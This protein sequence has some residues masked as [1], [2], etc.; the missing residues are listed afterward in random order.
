MQQKKGRPQLHHAQGL[1][2]KEIWDDEKHPHLPCIVTHPPFERA[3]EAGCQVIIGKRLT[4]N[5]PACSRPFGES[6]PR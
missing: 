4:V 5:N 3:I 2:I 1:G 6:T